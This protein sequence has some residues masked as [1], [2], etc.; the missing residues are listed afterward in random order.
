MADDTPRIWNDD[1]KYDP[2]TGEVLEEG[3]LDQTD[4]VPV[5]EISVPTTSEQNEIIQKS[6]LSDENKALLSS[7]VELNAI[8]DVMDQ[9]AMTETQEKQKRAIQ[10]ICENFLAQRFRNN[11]MAE[12]L[13][14]ALLKRLLDNIDNLDLATTAQIYN[15]LHDV[16]SQEAVAAFGQ[17]LG[18]AAGGIPGTNGG[19]NLT[20][21]NATA[22]GAAITTNTL[23][24][25]PQQVQ[26]LKEVAALNTSIRAWSGIPGKKQP[27]QAQ[28]VDNTQK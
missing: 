5:E 6:T 16:T 4:L 21:N 2:E 17:L 27:I 7:I 26:Q 15:D 28:I 22:D 24:A 12:Q 1:I 25:Q 14:L 11:Q 23:N 13:K 18:G 19:I 3:A 10:L 8:C 9:T 20:I